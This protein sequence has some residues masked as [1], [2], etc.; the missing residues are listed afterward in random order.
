MKFKKTFMLR[1]S[2]KGGF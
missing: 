2:Q 1:I